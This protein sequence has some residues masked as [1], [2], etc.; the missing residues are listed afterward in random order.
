MAQAFPDTEGPEALDGKKFH[1]VVADLINSVT[2]TGE[3]TSPSYDHTS[4]ETIEAANFSAQDVFKVMTEPNRN[5]EWIQIGV[6]H[7]VHAPRRIHSL[8]Y[9]TVDCF[10]YDAV[11]HHLYIWD[12]K[13]GY[14]LVEVFQNWQLIN[15][16]AA[17]FDEFNFN[18]LD[19]QTLTVHFRII[20]PRAFHRE[21]PI[22]E[23]T[24]RGSDLRPDFNILK[25][26]A[27]KAVS[28]DATTRSGT[29]CR[30]C[31]ARHACKTA[32]DA[33]M[34]LYEV[35]NKTT[36][37]DLSAEALGTQYAIVK[38]AREQLEYLESGLEEELKSRLRAGERIPG[39]HME[40]GRGRES[41]A[42]PIKE[43]RHLGELMGVA[44]GKDEVITPFQ[45]RK[46]GIDATIIDR[47]VEIPR[48]G[49]KLVTDDGSQVK[50][51]F[52]TIGA[53]MP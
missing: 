37:L 46:L 38:R 35:A 14:G 51:I 18:G 45:A 31:P 17:L 27:T 25:M 10:L 15:Y 26:N 33:G 36:P 8:S 34:Q 30:Y 40:P 16:A 43:I 3:K 53:K 11:T 28:N 13:Y 42:R 6:E 48:R 39:F 29:H 41:W 7:Q 5:P 21:G 23:W 9:G 2:R 52:S 24:V 22:R 19:D 49:N 32:L 1:E 12:F 4:A 50:R 44:L 20:Q 47:Y